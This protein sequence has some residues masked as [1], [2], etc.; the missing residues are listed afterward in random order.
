MEGGGYTH[1]HFLEQCH[2]QREKKKWGHSL[3]LGRVGSV[4]E[5]NM[6]NGRRNQVGMRWHM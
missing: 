6:G 1:L 3:D 5:V 4:W 2:F